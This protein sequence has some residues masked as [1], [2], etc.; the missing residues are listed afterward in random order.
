MP[1][2]LLMVAGR[3]REWRLP[4]CIRGGA[5]RLRGGDVVTGPDVDIARAG[6]PDGDVD[7]I[8]RARRL[9]RQPARP[10]NDG[11]VPLVRPGIARGRGVE[12]A[13][14]ALV[15]TNDRALI[16]PAGQLPAKPIGE[17]AA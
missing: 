7:G 10:Q 1:P 16:K 6:R 12:P 2:R 14:I 8:D 17:R 3:H 5:T 15:V 11:L 9:P 13:I 4:A